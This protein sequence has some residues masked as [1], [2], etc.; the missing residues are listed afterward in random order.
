V[1]LEWADSYNFNPHKWLL[2]NFDCSPMWFKNKDEVVDAFN[3]DPIIMKHKHQ[4]K[5]KC[6]G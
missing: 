1:G 3:V 6:Q 2:V 4:V 5:V